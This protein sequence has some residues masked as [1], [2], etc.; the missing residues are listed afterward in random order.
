MCAGLRPMHARREG[1][2][3]D[4]SGELFCDLVSGNSLRVPGPSKQLKMIHCPR[5]G[6]RHH[7]VIKPKT[8]NKKRVVG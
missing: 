7:G 1:W 2:R 3:W 6:S 4:P 5:E 8:K